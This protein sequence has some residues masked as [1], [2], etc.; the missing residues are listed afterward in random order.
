MPACLVTA[1]QA[2]VIPH[3]RRHTLSRGAFGFTATTETSATTVYWEKVEVPICHEI[4]FEPKRS[5]IP[6][7]MENILSLAF[8]TG[9]IIWHESLSLSGSDCYMIP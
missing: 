5:G 6:H 9:R 8:E 7:K 3:P 1:P 2:V 4:S